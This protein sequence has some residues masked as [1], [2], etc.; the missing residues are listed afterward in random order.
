M[1]DLP[2]AYII[3]RAVPFVKMGI[4]CCADLHDN[5]GYHSHLRENHRTGE[6]CSP[7]ACMASTARRYGYAPNDLKGEW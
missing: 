7:R 2:F 1:C 5:I 6:Q 4:G 3:R